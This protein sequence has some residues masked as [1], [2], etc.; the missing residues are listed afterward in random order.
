MGLPEVR[1]EGEGLPEMR[2][3]GLGL[4]ETRGEGLAAA[5]LGEGLPEGQGDGLL[6]GGGGRAGGRRG[7]ASAWGR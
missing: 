4:L 7:F 6:S 3:D 1:E 5:G 2:G